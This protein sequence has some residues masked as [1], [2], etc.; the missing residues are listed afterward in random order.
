MKWERR[1]FSDGVV[2][3][4][5]SRRQTTTAAPSPPLLYFRQ[6]GVLCI[7]HRVAFIYS[8]SAG[9]RRN[10]AA[11]L[12]EKLPCNS[13][14]EF[15]VEHASIR[16]QTLLLP[17][18]IDCVFLVVKVT[19]FTTS[20]LKSDLNPIAGVPYHTFNSELPYHGQRVI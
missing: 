11:D 2:R 6:V 13:A 20:H 15:F 17:Y 12:S 14:P 10:A 9:N 4:H 16:Q 5:I 3:P 7:G 18:C 1:T 8:D 19:F